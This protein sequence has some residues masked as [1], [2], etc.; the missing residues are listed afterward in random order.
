MSTVFNALYIL[1]IIISIVIISYA[2]LCIPMLFVSRKY[3]C[4]S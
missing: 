3:G 2:C 1:Y 4:I